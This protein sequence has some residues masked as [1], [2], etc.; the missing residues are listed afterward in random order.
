MTGH[1]TSETSEKQ[2]SKSRA[3]TTLPVE[4][5]GTTY[6]VRAGSDPSHL[7][8]LAEIVDG[9]MREIA[10]RTATVETSRIAILAAL[11][12]ADELVRARSQTESKEI[13]EQAHG[14]LD[15]LEK[16]LERS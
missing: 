1:A 2:G 4:I 3:T 5:Y 6:H 14:L 9:K 13:A 16:A 11:N 12:L 8:S 15:Q 7:E 10:G